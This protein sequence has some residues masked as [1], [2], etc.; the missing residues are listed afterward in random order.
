MLREAVT[1]SSQQAI[2]DD[3]V[4]VKHAKCA[5]ACQKA[6]E[7]LPPVTHSPSHSDDNDGESTLPKPPKKGKKW[8][9]I[10]DVSS[11]EEDDNF[12]GACGCLWGACLVQNGTSFGQGGDAMEVHGVLVQHPMAHHSAKVKVGDVKWCIIQPR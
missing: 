3:F 5:E 7:N 6:I 4:A 9:H 8:P 2:I 10:S 12:W 11:E 1:L